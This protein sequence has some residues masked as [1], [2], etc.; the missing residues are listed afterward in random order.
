[1][2]INR[3]LIDSRIQGFWQRTTVILKQAE[4]RRRD[5]EEG[6]GNAAEPGTPVCSGFP[7]RS[8]W[9]ALI[10]PVNRRRDSQLPDVAVGHGVLSI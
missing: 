4:T 8:H 7:W 3:L 5:R 10:G 2:G 9:C 1:M 6:M